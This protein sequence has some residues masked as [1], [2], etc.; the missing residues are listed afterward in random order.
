[1]NHCIDLV[2]VRLA[3]DFVS[4]FRMIFTFQFHEIKSKM[5]SSAKQS[6]TQIKRL[7]TSQTFQN[8]FDF[9]YLYADED[10]IVKKSN[11]QHQWFIK[12]CFGAQPI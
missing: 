4:L 6:L 2:C 12:D 5:K 8:Y 1:M 11:S 7:W 10:T 9:K 3:F